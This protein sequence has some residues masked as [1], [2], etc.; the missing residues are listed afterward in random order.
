MLLPSIT[1]IWIQCQIYEKWYNKLIMATD[2][3]TGQFE[4]SFPKSTDPVNVHGDLEQLAEDVKESLESIDVSIIQI[5]VKNVSGGTLPAGTP[6]YIFNYSEN[7]PGVKQYTEDLWDSDNVKPV[8]GLLKTSLSNNATGKVVVAGVLANVNTSSFTTGD[9]LYV[10]RP[11][12]EL[13][14]TRPVEGSGAV[15]IVGYAHT[16]N[17]V[18]IVEAKGN[19]TWGALKAGLA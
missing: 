19:G 9:V 12:G 5:D 10:G 3:T 16:T 13:T 2:K 18:I 6:V 15:G 8:L 7:V 1:R 17:G 4:I 14:K 11:N